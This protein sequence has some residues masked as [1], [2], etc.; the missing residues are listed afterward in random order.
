MGYRD[1][2]SL[3]VV[4]ELSVCRAFYANASYW[5]IG[6]RLITVAGN[7]CPPALDDGF[8]RPVYAVITRGFK[9]DVTYVDADTIVLS[10][11]LHQERIDCLASRLDE[12]G[13]AY[14]I[15][16]EGRLLH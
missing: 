16:L 7:N 10:R 3:E 1:I 2:D 12:A 9:G 6:D 8:P 15:G 14:R 13:R 11:A 4:T 5:A